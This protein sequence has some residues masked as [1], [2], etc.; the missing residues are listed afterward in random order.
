MSR[1]QRRAVARQQAKATFQQPASSTI[2][3]APMPAV[4]KHGGGPQTPQG[5]VISSQNALSHG[6]TSAKLVLPWENQA[7]FDHLLNGLLAEHQPATITEEIMVKKMAEQY[8]RLIRARNKEH[9]FYSNCPPPDADPEEH[10]RWE[11]ALLL[12]Q[13]YATRHERAFHKCL[14]TLR[15]LQKERRAREAEAQA[16]AATPQPQPEFVSQNASIPAQFV[17][18]IAETSGTPVNENQLSANAA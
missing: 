3:T 7:E 6:L 1:Q 8:W 12:T 18:Q 14:S 13:R 9:F 17:S 11:K 4:P 5:K 15:T 2:A 16:E 10:A